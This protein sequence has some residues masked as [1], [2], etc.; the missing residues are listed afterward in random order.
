MGK[1]LLG[2]SSEY[3]SKEAITTPMIPRK[4]P[5]S[6][7]SPVSPVPANQPPLKVPPVVPSIPGGK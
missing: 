4:T 5:Y 2:H 7:M 1:R 6:P 3:F